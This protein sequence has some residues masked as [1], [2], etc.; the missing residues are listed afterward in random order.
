MNSQFRF[1]LVFD[2][3]VFLFSLQNVHL[4]TIFVVVVLFGSFQFNSEF[5]MQ[6]THA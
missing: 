6:T 4:H 5:I 1:F 2:L 3:F